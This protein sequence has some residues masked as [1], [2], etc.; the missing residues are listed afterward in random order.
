M[1]TSTLDVEGVVKTS[2]VIMES[3]RA[4]IFYHQLNISFL[5]C[6]PLLWYQKNGCTAENVTWSLLCRIPS[7]PF[8]PSISC[9]CELCGLELEDI[10]HL[11]I[12]RHFAS[13]LV[14][15]QICASICQ[16]MEERGNSNWVQFL[17]ECSNI[18]EVI[19]GAQKDDLILSLLLKVICRWC[20]RGPT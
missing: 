6:G 3:F 5:N 19:S 12:Q 15:S 10:D 16:C 20:N 9:L 2:Q 18:P 1:K 14:Q 13:I 11:P 4:E 7:S 17:L 8:F